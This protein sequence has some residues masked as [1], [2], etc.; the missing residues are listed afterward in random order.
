LDQ[1]Q[2]AAAPGSDGPGGDLSEG[3]HA[4]HKG[5]DQEP[6]ETAAIHGR[7]HRA[8]ARDREKLSIRTARLQN[9]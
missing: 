2:E 3:S 6:T 9:R 8:N 1:H 7:Q 4:P 5:T